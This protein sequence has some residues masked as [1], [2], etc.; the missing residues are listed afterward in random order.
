M[1]AETP[2]RS[3]LVLVSFLEI[4][5]E[6]IKDLLNP[7]DKQLMIREHPDLGVYVQVSRIVQVPLCTPQPPRARR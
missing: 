3:F 2:S 7:S 5:N 1:Q 4:Y 6:C